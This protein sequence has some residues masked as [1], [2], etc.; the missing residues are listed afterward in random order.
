MATYHR[1]Q[2]QTCEL[3]VASAP[4]S[5]DHC[6]ALKE[7]AG[8]DVNLFRVEKRLR[9]LQ[10]KHEQQSKQQYEQEKQRT[11]VFDFINSTLTGKT[12]LQCVQSGRMRT[13]DKVTLLR[14]CV[15]CLNINH[16]TLSF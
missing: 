1:D 4:V 14:Q 10:Q 2:E 6:M 9:R 12:G 13:T 5:I 8:G 7:K 11:N 3:H 15:T 16:R